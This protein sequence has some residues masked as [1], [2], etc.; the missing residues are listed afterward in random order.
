MTRQRLD[1]MVK[2]H[3]QE[4]EPTSHCSAGHAPDQD[5][6]RGRRG[7]RGDAVGKHARQG[8][9]QGPGQ[10][11]ERAPATPR[12][13]V[14]HPFVCTDCHMEGGEEQGGCRDEHRRRAVAAAERA[15]HRDARAEHEQR[16]AE[17]GADVVPRQCHSHAR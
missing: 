6:E 3:E 11:P 10:G 17:D 2:Q 1:A 5:G 7:D 4:V 9:G 13:R 12:R 8:R 15:A 14:V 16:D